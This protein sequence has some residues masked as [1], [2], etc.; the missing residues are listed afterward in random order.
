[1]GSFGSNLGSLSKKLLDDVKERVDSYRAENGLPSDIPVPAD[2]VT[3]SGSGLD[4]HISLQNAR[5]QARRV[6]LA[7]AVNLEEVEKAIRA[8]TEGRTLGV[9]GEERINVFKLNLALDGK[10]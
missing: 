7:R 4:P 2:A 3:A 6:A 10:R 9:F 5:R 1:V 8:H